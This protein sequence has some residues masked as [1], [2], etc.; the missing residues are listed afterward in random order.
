MKRSEVQPLYLAVVEIMNKQATK[1]TARWAYGITKNYNALKPEFEAIQQAQEKALAEYLPEEKKIVDKFNDIA[2][3]IPAEEMKDNKILKEAIEN[4][5]KE[6]LELR[7]KY[8]DQIKEWEDFMEDDVEIKLFKINPD[9]LPDVETD[10]INIMVLDQ[11]IR[12]D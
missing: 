8:Q 1:P 2:K 5:D 4:R 11:I 6:L 7:E 12:E 10:W 3:E 9:D